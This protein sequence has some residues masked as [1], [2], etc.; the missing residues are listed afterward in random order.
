[1]PLL[2]LSLSNRMADLAG[3]GNEKVPP[4]ERLSC[5]R[6]NLNSSSQWSTPWLAAAGQLTSTVDGGLPRSTL[7]SK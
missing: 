1:M 4:I 2:F 6:P 3:S 5:P 7:A